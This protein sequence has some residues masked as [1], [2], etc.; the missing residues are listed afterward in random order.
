MPRVEASWE[1]PKYSSYSILNVINPLLCWQDPHRHPAIRGFKVQ[2]FKQE[3]QRTIDL[4]TTTDT[5][6]PLPTDEY[7]IST[8]YKIRVAT[9]GLDDRQ[10]SYEESD[11]LVA[12]PLRFDFSS[13]NVA[14]LPDGRSL[15]TQRLLFLII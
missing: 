15:R 5:Y 12:S 2:M 6:M 3:D 13:A 9:I 4:G 14:T 1:A 8:S 11:T 10:S 7:N